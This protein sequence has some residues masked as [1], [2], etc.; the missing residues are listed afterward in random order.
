MHK[1]LMYSRLSGVASSMSM[2]CN[3]G[4]HSAHRNIGYLQPFSNF[5]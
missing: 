2:R 3:S 5:S 4:L 1:Y